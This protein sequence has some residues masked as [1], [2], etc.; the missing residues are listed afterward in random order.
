V[1]RAI[2]D[3]GVVVPDGAHIGSGQRTGPERYHVSATGIVVLGKGQ[4][5]IP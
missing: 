2:L 3:K 4:L 5:A 1:R